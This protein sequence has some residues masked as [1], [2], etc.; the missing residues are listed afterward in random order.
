M[1]GI[2]GYTGPQKTLDILLAGLKNLE[3]RGYDSAGVAV[4][5]KKS[6][7]FSLKVKGR[8]SA[9]D[10]SLKNVQAD[11]YKGAGI[12]HTRWATHGVP[13]EINAHP[14][15]DCSGKIWV[16]HNGIIENYRT[17]KKNLE[18]EGHKFISETD[19]EVLSHLIE[20]YY[21][22]P[23][24]GGLEN[25]VRLALKEV[26]GAYGIAV[27]SASEPDKIIAARYSSPLI[28]GIGSEEVFVASDVS[29][30]INYTRKV[31]Y[32]D[33]AE[34][35]V[36]TPAGYRISDLEN[37]VVEKQIKEV[38]WE[39]KEA[40]KEGFSHFLFKE[41]YEAPEAI[42]NA[43][44][45]RINPEDGT[46]KLGGLEMAEKRLAEIE[47]LIIVACGSAFYAAKVGEYMIEEY[48]G[49]ATE[50]EIG[51]EF[52][53]K[54]PILDKKTAI[55]AISQSGET[56]DTLMA[57]KEAKRKGSFAF[58]L[59]NTVG[60]SIARECGV[61]VY[62]HAGMEIAVPASKSF[63]SQVSILALLAVFLGRQRQMSSVMG[64]RIL[65]ELAALPALAE[66]VLKQGEAIGK[67]AKKYNS[68]KNFA[69]LGRKYN[70]PIAL[71]G[72]LKLKEVAYC[73][74][75]E[76]L[77]AGEIKHGPI[78]MIDKNFPSVVIAPQDS[79]YEKMINAIQEI[80][81][82]NGRVIAVATEGDREV[83]IS[84]DDVIYI[85][86][87]L[88][89]LTPILAAIPLYLFAAHLGMLNKCDIDKPRN[90]A[91]SVTVE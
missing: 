29:A 73:V 47:R 15:K 89:M 70:Y 86:K 60:S 2:I 51:S 48:A 33:D 69:F 38:S 20:K 91:K 65:K 54:K 61:G 7:I 55:L 34:M 71:E 84:A 59:V 26:I 6:G 28:L 19:T 68:Y 24:V 1:C 41:I 67:L 27:I 5:G 44:R 88:E 76:G 39:I 85:P 4:V 22:N 3:Y 12:A 16:A 64:A 37:H 50:A 62:N 78:A 72:A 31:I 18:A 21:N 23:S 75:A 82:R 58:G 77:P 53:Y 81:A 36:V 14:H 80:K 25:A 30:V 57:V 87:T 32:L 9:L 63:I 43:I 83:K 66:Q 49:I 10:D 11:E 74:H 35:A 40:R 42:K 56:A 45:G 8:V 79:V 13:S 17:L 46:A 90:L 52:R